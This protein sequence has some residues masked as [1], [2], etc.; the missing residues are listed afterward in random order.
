MLSR[1]RFKRTEEKNVSAVGAPLFAISRTSL[2][3]E[4]ESKVGY[5]FCVPG[6]PHRISQS[7]INPF[8]RESP[9][10]GTS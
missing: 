6:F 8:C 5:E 1:G 4:N 7:G 10:Q 2:R 3:E 9:S